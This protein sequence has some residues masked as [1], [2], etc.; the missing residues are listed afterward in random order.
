MNK[1]VNLRIFTDAQDKFNL[2]ALDIGGGIL[3]IS[4]FT[5]LAD[6]RKGRRPSFEKA[7]P[8]AEA[9]KLFEYCVGLA[10]AAGWVAPGVSSSTC[11]WKSIM[12]VPNGHAGQ[13]EKFPRSEE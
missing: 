8:P 6:A 1:V 5:L 3:L 11:W 4:Q 7:A 12:R 10:R 9:E 2:S 13:P